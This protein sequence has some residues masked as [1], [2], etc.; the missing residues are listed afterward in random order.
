MPTAKIRSVN[1]NYEVL[2][3]TGPWVA[4]SPGGRRGLDALKS[5]GRRLEGA[6]FRILLHDRRNCGASDVVIEG[7]ESEYEIWADDLHSLLAQVG[8][9]EA[10]IGG[11]SAGCRLSLLFAIR[12]PESTQGLLLWRVTGGRFAVDRLAEQY[13]GEFIRA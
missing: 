3:E 6:G 1:I 11:A 8:A 4:L 12:H 5:L 7:E 2:G 10:F 9:S 13:Y